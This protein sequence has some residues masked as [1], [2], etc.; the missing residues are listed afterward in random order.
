MRVADMRGKSQNSSNKAGSSIAVIQSRST[1]RV[2]AMRL[3]AS[4]FGPSITALNARN[5]AA[6][7]AP[8]IAVNGARCCIPVR[9]IRHAKQLHAAT[10]NTAVVASAMPHT[11]GRAAGTAKGKTRREPTTANKAAIKAPRTGCA[12]SE[13]EAVPMYGSSAVAK[14]GVIA[15]RTVRV[16]VGASS[17][18]ARTRS[19]GAINIPN[20]TKTAFHNW[21]P[22][23]HSARLILAIVAPI[24]A[25]SRK[26][27]ES[28]AS[29]RPDKERIDG[30]KSG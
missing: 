18:D 17:S 8:A 10:R 5:P 26:G 11:D 6:V 12:L 4:A 15:K 9:A 21:G 30:N 22:L 23:G 3:C 27:I 19:A 29:E 1:E 25:S 2:S 14:I 13:P 20:P 28:A 7:P 16:N 24:K